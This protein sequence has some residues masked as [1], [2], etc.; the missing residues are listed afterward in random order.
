MS[1]PAIQHREVPQAEETLISPKT[2][3]PGLLIPVLLGTATAISILSVSFGIWALNRPQPPQPTAQMGAVMAQIPDEI[4]PKRTATLKFWEAMIQA[5]NK[6]MPAI[7]AAIDA[8]KPNEEPEVALPKLCHLADV[9]SSECEKWSAEIKTLNVL[10][11]DEMLLNHFREE[12]RINNQG[13]AAF[14]GIAETSVAFYQWQ[15]KKSAAPENILGDMIDSFFQGMMGRPF[16]GYEK[17]KGDAAK[18]DAEGQL[19]VERHLA[20]RKSLTS[21]TEESTEHS[22]KEHQLRSDLSRK[23]QVE[24]A[25]RPE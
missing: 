19:L 22:I 3:S 9:T 17:L 10:H 8:Y 7:K 21:T 12:L 6:T 18:L 20:Y 2:P 1:E 24:F 5:D 15:K 11:V 4:G 14:N 16:A 23:Y 13:A 25:P